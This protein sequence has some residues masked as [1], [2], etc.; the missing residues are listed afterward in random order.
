MTPVICLSPE[1]LPPDFLY[2]IFLC[3]MEQFCCRGV[4]KAPCKPQGTEITPD[5]LFSVLRC[6]ESCHL[7][8]HSGSMLFA[9]TW[10]PKPATSSEFNFARDK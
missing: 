9:S 3:E 7:E 10:V 1:Y 5:F 6:F 2:S 8:A 4:L